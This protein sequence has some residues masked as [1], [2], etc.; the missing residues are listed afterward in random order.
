MPGADPSLF[1]CLLLEHQSALLRYI[2][3]LVGNLDDAQDV[4]QQTALALWQKFGQYDPARPFL[5]FAKRFAHNEV[6]MHY[7][8]KQ[9]HTSRATFLT[10]EL[11]ETLAEEQAEQDPGEPRRL[12]L[13]SCLEALP[14][15][16]RRL[17]DERYSESGK[18]IDRLAGETGRKANV[19]YKALA[20]IR[21][22]LLRCVSEKLALAQGT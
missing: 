20:R 3:P 21:R 18:T 22:Q 13:Q 6:L 16:D 19:L 1:V 15:A 8:N 11:I 10:K 4:F 17:L 2:L 7:R 5:P 12:A 14:E 9:K